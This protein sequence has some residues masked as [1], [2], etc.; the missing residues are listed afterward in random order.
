MLEDFIIN[1]LKNRKRYL[2]CFIAFIFSLLLVEYGFVKT[3]FI[4]IVSFLG[5]VSGTPNLKE[6]LKKI[7]KDLD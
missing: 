4:F 7:Y 3:V 5:Y 1:F 6:T 2:R